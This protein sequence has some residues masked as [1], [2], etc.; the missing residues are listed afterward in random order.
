MCGIAGIFSSSPPE[1]AL[2]RRMSDAIEHRGPDDEGVWVDRNCGIGF[3]HRRLS[4]VDLSASGHQPMLSPDARYVLNYNGEIYNHRALRAEIEAAEAVSEGGWIGHSDTEV[5]LAAIGAWGLEAALSKAVGMFALALWDASTRTLTLA[6][7]RFGEKPLYYGWAGK[8]FLFGSELK[9]LRVHPGFDNPVSRQALA[10]FAS[11]A[12][13]P[14]PLSIFERIFK[15]PPG[16]MLSVTRE[17]CG[18]PR[19]EPVEEGKSGNGLR[20]SRYWSYRDVVRRGL[21]DPIASEEDSLEA[22]EQALVAA[23]RDQSVADVPVGAFLSGGIDSSTIVALYQHHAPGSVRTF[24]IGFE[25]AGYDE[26]GHAQAVAERLGTAHNEYYVTVRE[27]MDAIPSLPAIYDEPFADSSQIPTFLV[28]RFARQQV[29]V[30]L[31]GDGGDEL[32][33]GYVRHFAAPDL[34]RRASRLPRPLR[35]VAGATLGRIP[36]SFWNAAR[37]ILP[38]Q[39]QPHFGAKMQRA[40]Q[41]LASAGSFD[42]VYSSFLDEWSVEGVSPVRG[43]G[44]IGAPFDLEIGAPAPD[45]L[46][47]MY[48]D[49]TSYL[50]DDILSKVD[51]ASM[52]VSLETRVPFLDHRVAELAARIPLDLK[53]R[54]GVGK[55]IIRELLYRHVPRKLFDRPKTGFAVPVAEWIKGPLR[56]WAEDLLD[57]RRMAEEGWF[58]P[59]IVRRRWQD[60]LSGRRSSPQALWA[61]LMFQSWLRQEKAPVAAAA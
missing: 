24:T 10:L 53:L 60:H 31:T 40:T 14:A 21:A 18:A 30:A 58:D 33:G 23:I 35:S 50:P 8:D 46:R 57:E 32:F 36:S 26:A 34:W 13:V 52:A 49:A 7:D 39:A 3:A 27:A 22:L 47:V 38:G 15:L 61:V 54:N 6:R 37:E 19:D 48:C 5:L 55:H 16:C 45:A 44:I 2:L 43:S 41:V 56:G 51:R 1:P 20:L 11:R 25:E 9:A 4:I 59:A 17:A 12:Y 29:K 42:D 28:S